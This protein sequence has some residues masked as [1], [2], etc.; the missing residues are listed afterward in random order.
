MSLTR[1]RFNGLGGL[2]S[3]LLV[4]C[5][6]LFFGCTKSK[7]LSWRDTSENESGFRIYRM[8][9]AT[10]TLVGKVPANVTHFTDENAPSNARYL[11]TAFK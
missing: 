10:K 6:V 1:L 8:A 3:L 7:S 9:E 5:A 2:T 11:V 4:A